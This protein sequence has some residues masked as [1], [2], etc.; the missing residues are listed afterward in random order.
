M[1]L[2]RAL[3]FDTVSSM[4]RRASKNNLVFF[5]LFPHSSSQKE[6]STVLKRFCHLSDRTASPLN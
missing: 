3:E 6:C 1:L 2:S 4:S 5:F